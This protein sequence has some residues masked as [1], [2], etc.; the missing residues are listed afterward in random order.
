MHVL[1]V[2]DFARRFWRMLS[3]ALVFQF[4]IYKISDIEDPQI[5]PI[6]YSSSASSAGGTT[7]QHPFTELSRIHVSK[8]KRTME[9]VGEIASIFG[10]PFLL[11]FLV[12]YIPSSNR[13]DMISIPKE[14]SHR[15]PNSERNADI[16]QNLTTK[17][18]D[19]GR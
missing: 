15:H 11:Q 10:N 18:S 2:L 7:Y 9:G 12:Q 14:I 17:F 13:R 1:K 8:K 16:K 4:S 3:I 6:I 19:D 5:Y